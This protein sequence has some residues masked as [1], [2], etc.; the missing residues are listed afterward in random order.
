MSSQQTEH[1]IQK[2][3]PQTTERLCQQ[4]EDATW[5]NVKLVNIAVQIMHCTNLDDTIC[6]DDMSQQVDQT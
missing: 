4:Q 5:G 6:I 1:V 3:W 2:L